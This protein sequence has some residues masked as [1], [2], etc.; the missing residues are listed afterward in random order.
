MSRI[1]YTNPVCLLT[2]CVPNPLPPASGEGDAVAPPATAG[3]RN[4]MVVSWLVSHPPHPRQEPK[5]PHLPPP[6]P[7]PT[8]RT[9]RENG[10]TFA[11]LG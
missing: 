5:A 2:T 1:L 8:A 10:E 9:L 6:A 4:A 7:T 3:E 11:A